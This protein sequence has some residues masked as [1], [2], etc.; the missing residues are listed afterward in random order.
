MQATVP[1]S[2]EEE[3]RALICGADRC[4]PGAH[5]FPS[6]WGLCGLHSAG[7]VRCHHLFREASLASQPLLGSASGFLKSTIQTCKLKPCKTRW[8]GDDKTAITM[9]IFYSILV[10]L[11]ELSLLIFLKKKQTKQNNQEAG[12]TVIPIFKWGDWQGRVVAHKTT[13]RRG[14]TAH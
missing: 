14:V 2:A 3:K 5:S 4:H 8:S 11:H 7:L 6:E 12:T 10:A 9:N 1:S 13:E